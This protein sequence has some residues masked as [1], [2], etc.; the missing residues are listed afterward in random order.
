MRF[1]PF[2]E[3]IDVV[4][5]YR[6]MR[7]AI[8]TS[9]MDPRTGKI[10][11]ALLT[12]G[13]SSGARKLHE[14]MRKAMVQLLDRED[15]DV[16]RSARSGRGVRYMELVKAFGEQSS[17]RVD[18]VEVAEVLRELEGEGVVGVSGGFGER[19]FVRRIVEG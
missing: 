9:A 13:T 10:D 5:S 2:V 15:S 4:E 18:L 8:K 6:L 17:I 12:T 19:G 14:D 1:S 16:G 3:E 11:M 7:E